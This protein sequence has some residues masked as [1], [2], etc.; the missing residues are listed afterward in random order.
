MEIGG[1][2]VP[3]P[4]AKLTIIDGQGHGVQ[5]E[6]PDRFN[7]VVTEFLTASPREALR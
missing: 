2:G 7:M 3:D 1:I 4:G 6:A 5:W